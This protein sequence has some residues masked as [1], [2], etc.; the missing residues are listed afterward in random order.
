M[1]SPLEQAQEL[2]RD[3]S[4]NAL[5]LITK[6]KAKT[7]LETCEWLKEHTEMP[8]YEPDIKEAIT[9]CRRILK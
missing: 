8:N 3:F 1:K 6:E 5:I 7:L 4:T 2:R 9:I